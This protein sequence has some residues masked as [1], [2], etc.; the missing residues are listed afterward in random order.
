MIRPSINYKKPLYLSTSN[1]FFLFLE[2]L[3]YLPIFVCHFAWLL[4]TFLH[5]CLPVQ[6]TY[7]LFY[8]LLFCMLVCL[9]F[10]RMRSSLLRMR[11]SLVVRASDCQCTGCN[12]PGFDPSIRRHSG[13][14][15][16]AD[17]AVL[18][19]VRTKRKK[20]PKKIFKKKKKLSCQ[21][22]LP[23]NRTY[24]GAN[25]PATC[26]YCSYNLVTLT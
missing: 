20:S 2:Y 10:M 1:N 24:L 9:T 19:N 6:Y 17:E 8:E 14:W 5:V 4:N 13:I 18:N 23:S 3:P 25:T 16:A 7:D 11:S 22:F 15:G 21:F 26:M 12:G